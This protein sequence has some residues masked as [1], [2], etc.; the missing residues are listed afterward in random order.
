METKS[1]ITDTECC[2]RANE[3]RYLYVSELNDG[4]PFQVNV[5]PDVEFYKVSKKD[6]NGRTSVAMF[7]SYRFDIDIDDVK[8]C[9]TGEE[10]PLYQ[11]MGSRY[12]YNPRIDANEVDFLKLVYQYDILEGDKLSLKEK[13]MEI[14]Y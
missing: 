6:Y 10:I 11:F 12:R 7:P 1:L 3:T 14:W 4:K 2:G 5:I 13:E 8:N 9:L